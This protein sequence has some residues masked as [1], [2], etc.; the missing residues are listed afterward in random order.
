MY[1][2]LP[3]AGFAVVEAADQLSLGV[4]VA[5]GFVIFWLNYRLHLAQEAQRAIAATATARAER[6]DAAN[7]SSPGCSTT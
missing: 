5:T 2:F 6:L 4:F 1:F 7:A 3:P